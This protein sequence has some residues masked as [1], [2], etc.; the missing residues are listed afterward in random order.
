MSLEKKI[1]G[2]SNLKQRLLMRPAAVAADNP[3]TG[4]TIENKS[5]YFV[6][7]DCATVTRDYLTLFIYGQ[8]HNP[9]ELLEGKISEKEIRGRYNPMPML[10][11]QDAQMIEGFKNAVEQ[12][13]VGDKV[14]VYIP[15]QLGYG[16][17]G[18]GIIAPKQDL[19]FIISMVGIQ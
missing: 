5:A 12:M 2:V 14:Y 15:Y 10:L 16:E 8:L 3:E 18:S 4:V 11:S 1:L 19:I 13:R 7:R 9:F 6:I 17:N